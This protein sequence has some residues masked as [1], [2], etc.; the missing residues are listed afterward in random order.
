LYTRRRGVGGVFQPWGKGL[1][2]NLSSKVVVFCRMHD[3]SPVKIISNPGTSRSR[4]EQSL[5][6]I[7]MILR[8]SSAQ[9]PFSR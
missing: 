8:H 1:N 5:K 2:D 6:K 4:R 3:K 7:L 9:K